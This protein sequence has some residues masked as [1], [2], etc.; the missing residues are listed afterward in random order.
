MTGTQAEMGAQHGRLVA[1]DAKRL[2]EFYRAM[3]ANQLAGGEGRLAQAVMSRFAE[4]WQRRLASARPAELA[5]RTRAFNDAAGVG[6]GAE[7]AYATMDSLQNCVSVVARIGLGPFARPLA[8]RVMA[9]AQPACSTVIAWGDATEDGELL[10][11]RNF[12]FP[13]VG[14]WD[15]APAFTVCVERGGMRYG[16]FAAKGADVPVVTVVNA[17]GLVLAPHTRWHRGVTWGGGMIV[18]VVHEIARRAECLADAETI[19]RELAPSSSWGIAVG[20]AREKAAM[21]IEAA[22]GRVEIVRPPAGASVMACTNRYRSAALQ[23][24]QVAG[25]AAWAIHADR[26][27][28]RLRGLLAMHG[29]GLEPRDLVAMLADRRDPE[30]PGIERHLGAIVAQPTNV[31]AAVVKPSARQAWVGVDRAPSCEGA[32]VRVDWQWDGAAGAMPDGMRAEAVAGFAPPQDAATRHVYDA[33]VAFETHHDVPAARAAIE[34]AV[35]DAPGDPSL[36]LAALWLAMADGEN[37]AAVAHADVGLAAETESYRRGQLLLWA[38]R[39]AASRAA[40]AR[41]ADQLAA[42][43]GDGV[44]ELQAAAKRRWRGKPH[45]NLMMHD[46][47]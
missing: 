21:V 38:S 5:A 28:K 22:G 46:A 29:G 20:S 40:R 2:L 13:G 14:V 11:A 27:E 10:F 42:L 9:A 45:A 26:R 3:P 34:R 4:A 39:A 15:A 36:R 12:D 31:H 17:A 37:A 1:G 44:A 35:A 8:A 32:W 18:D 30:A 7:L 6:A 33:V 24:G 16:F 23:A 47:Y 41:Y 19:A 43:R 25:S